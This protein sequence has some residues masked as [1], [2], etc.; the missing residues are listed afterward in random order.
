MSR[1]ESGEE[2]AAGDGPRQ[3]TASKEASG[4]SAAVSSLLV[5]NGTD[6]SLPSQS[7]TSAA[8]AA[9]HAESFAT[10]L[11]T[12]LLPVN[13]LRPD[14]DT[15]DARIADTERQLQQ[16]R[17]LAELNRELAALSVSPKAA[18]GARPG[19]NAW[20]TIL[21]G[22]P[23]PSQSSDPLQHTVLYVPMDD[24]NSKKPRDF[25]TY[26]TWLTEQQ[27]QTLAEAHMNVSALAS[28]KARHLWASSHSLGQAARD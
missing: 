2:T 16:A 21:S 14:T 9:E 8:A 23:P 28:A 15:L 11:T 20:T 26:K 4:G 3:P 18:T 6:P 19:D 13:V 1:R 17:K 12:P 25:L 24:R 5:S 27:I 22:A 7:Q 10:L